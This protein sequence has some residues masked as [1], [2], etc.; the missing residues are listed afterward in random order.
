MLSL[1]KEGTICTSVWPVEHQS[2]SLLSVC[3]W[4]G[5]LI[6]KLCFHWAS[7]YQPVVQR[8]LLH[9]TWPENSKLNTP[10]MYKRTLL[11]WAQ[12]QSG[13]ML[14]IVVPS[15]QGV[16]EVSVFCWCH[17]Y[18]TSWS[19]CGSDSISSRCWLTASQPHDMAYPPHACSLCT[20]TMFFQSTQK[21]AGCMP[22]PQNLQMLYCA[23]D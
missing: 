22:W 3:I 13:N 6:S 20:G 21:L 7:M 8:V 14:V 1:L 4:M 10:S 5:A 12:G 2:N 16:N 19:C 23:G 18:V 15:L 17:C 11:Q 9:W